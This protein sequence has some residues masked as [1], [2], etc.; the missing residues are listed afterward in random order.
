MVFYTPIGR[1]LVGNIIH[2][3]VFLFHDILIPFA[4][5]LPLLQLVAPLPFHRPMGR[6]FLSLVFPLMNLS[7]MVLTTLSVVGDKHLVPLSSIFV[8]YG[9]SYYL[10]G[11]SL[12]D[13]YYYP[14]VI[15]I[16]MYVYT[17]HHL[18]L[19]GTEISIELLILLLPCPV[20][21]YGLMEEYSHGLAGKCLVYLGMI[22]TFF[23]L[24]YD[25]TWVFPE[26]LPIGYRMIIQNT[27][28]I[29]LALIME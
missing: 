1:H 3:A 11:M 21:H 12:T 17:F 29:F 26:L 7:G 15:I 25:H 16:L 24:S 4:I 10:F 5:L 13:R 14:H 22:G 8:S 9:C 19:L 20:L 18:L 6:V 2:Y 28:L 27:P 23:T